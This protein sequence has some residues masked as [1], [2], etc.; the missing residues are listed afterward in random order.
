ME[1]SICQRSCNLGHC[2]DRWRTLAE[3]LLLR[4]S[5]R[6]VDFL[7]KKQQEELSSELRFEDLRSSSFSF[8]SITKKCPDASLLPARVEKKAICSFPLF[9]TFCLSIC[10]SSRIVCARG[11]S[12][13]LLVLSAFGF[14]LEFVLLSPLLIWFQSRVW[15]T[16]G[17]CK[18]SAIP[19]LFLVIP[20]MLSPRTRKASVQKANAGQ[21]QEG[22]ICR[23]P[24]FKHLDL[25]LAWH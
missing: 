15:S 11:F 2:P 7:T 14:L 10:A 4:S 21:E 25:T 8:T 12:G 24:L 9:R 16:K 19:W 6:N 20:A 18:R 23:S 13:V 5:P 3:P 22:S 17:S 1:D